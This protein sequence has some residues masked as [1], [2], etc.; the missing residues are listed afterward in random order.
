MLLGMGRVQ[1]CS[2]S[3]ILLQIWKRKMG[4]EAISSFQGGGIQV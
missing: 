2:D 1:H 4:W 3:W